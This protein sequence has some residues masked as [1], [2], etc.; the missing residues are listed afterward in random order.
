MSVVL[1]Q[2]KLFISKT[3]NQVYS[4]VTLKKNSLFGHH[5]ATLCDYFILKKNQLLSAVLW[6]IQ[7]HIL[8]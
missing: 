7:A 8:I 6:V 3:T 4:G 2:Y 1:E 5:Y